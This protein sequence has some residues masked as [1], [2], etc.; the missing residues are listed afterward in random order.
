[1]KCI[2][3]WWAVLSLTPLSYFVKSG[4]LKSSNFDNIFRA[5]SLDAVNEI[6]AVEARRYRQGGAGVLIPLTKSGQLKRNY[7]NKTSASGGLNPVSEIRAAEALGVTLRT[8]ATVLIPLMKS[9][10][11]KST[12]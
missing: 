7:L 4:Q 1:M 2:A 11:L 9:G 10:Q 8:I 12:L 6:R 3:A 5:A